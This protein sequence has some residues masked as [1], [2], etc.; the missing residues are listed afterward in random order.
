MNVQTSERIP[1][2][3]GLFAGKLALGLVWIAVAIGGAIL[4][5][6]AAIGLRVV[7]TALVAGPAFLWLSVLQR[8]SRRDELEARHALNALAQGGWWAVAFGALFYGLQAI[9]GAPPPAQLLVLLPA[10]GFLFGESMAQFGRWQMTR[11][12]P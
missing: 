9:N 5:E 2:G 8:Q 4:L 12:R 6:Q 10:M 11:G 7:G 1:V 3:W